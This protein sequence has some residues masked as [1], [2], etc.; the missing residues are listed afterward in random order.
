MRHFDKSFGLETPPE[1]LE[2]MIERST[3][4]DIT[5]YM[6]LEVGQVVTG[7]VKST[8]EFG[9]FVSLNSDLNGLL[10]VSKLPDDASPNDYRWGDLIDVVISDISLSE[11]KAKVSLDLNKKVS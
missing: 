4:N 6:G 1:A 9:I 7:K 8:K 2:E 10:H 5:T 11:G 3:A